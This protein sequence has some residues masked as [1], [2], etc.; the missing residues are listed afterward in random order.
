M[1][2]KFD[3]GPGRLGNKTDELFKCERYRNEDFFAMVVSFVLLVGSLIISR[4]PS[5]TNESLQFAAEMVMSVWYLLC[6][7]FVICFLSFI[8]HSRKYRE[9][10]KQLGEAEP[11]SKR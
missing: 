6:A 8:K 10:S 2:I 11:D 9:L 5:V 4:T 1:Y 3:R 7:C